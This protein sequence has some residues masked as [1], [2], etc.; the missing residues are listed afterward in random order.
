MR[1]ETKG[2]GRSGGG[3]EKK[4]KGGEKRGKE[5]GVKGIGEGE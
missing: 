2:R 5:G 3:G 1:R 4:K